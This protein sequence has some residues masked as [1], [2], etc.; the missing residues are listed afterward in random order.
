MSKEV[1]IEII[2]LM[3]SDHPDANVSSSLLQSQFEGLKAS[4]SNQKA[5]ELYLEQNDILDYVMVDNESK[6]YADIKECQYKI[7]DYFV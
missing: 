6:L 3:K 4:Q 7:I 1:T 2:R 5:V